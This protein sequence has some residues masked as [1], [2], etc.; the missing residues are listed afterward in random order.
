MNQ[1]GGKVQKDLRFQI[2]GL[3]TNI[4]NLL[5]SK[6]KMAEDGYKVGLKNILMDIG[7]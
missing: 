5:G 6:I 1:D 2:Y 7:V 4:L 3:G